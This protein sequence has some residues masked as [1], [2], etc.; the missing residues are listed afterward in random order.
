MVFKKFSLKIDVFCS[1]Y[2]WFSS[3]L[4]HNIGFKEKRPIFCLKLVK[5]AENYDGTPGFSNLQSQWP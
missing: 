1:K 2:C 5:I 3:N 4:D